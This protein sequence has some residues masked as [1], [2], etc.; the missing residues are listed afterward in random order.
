MVGRRRGRPTS[1]AQEPEVR[2]E[3]V[4]AKPTPLQ[5]RK[6][7]LLW[8]LLLQGDPAVPV[9]DEPPLN[10]ADEHGSRRHGDGQA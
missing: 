9:P 7:E 1:A 3:W 5:A 10:G 2:V 8:Q 4:R 6:W